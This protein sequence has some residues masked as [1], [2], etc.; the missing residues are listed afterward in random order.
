MSYTT[1]CNHRRVWF[2]CAAPCTYPASDGVTC[3]KY[4]S[5]ASADRF[6]LVKFHAAGGAAPVRAVQGLWYLQQQRV[7]DEERRRVLR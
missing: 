6:H 7:H 1:Y 5:S 2:R 3:V 4:W